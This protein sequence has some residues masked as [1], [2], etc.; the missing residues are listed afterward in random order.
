MLV[1]TNRSTKLEYMKEKAK[2]FANVTDKM[3]NEILML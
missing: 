3:K 1:I 2:G